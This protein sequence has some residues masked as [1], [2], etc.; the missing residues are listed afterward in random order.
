MSRIISYQ[1]FIEVVE[2]GSLIQTADKLHYSPA[3]ISKQLA[4]LEESLS[5]QLFH[6]S[7]KK[8]EITQAGKQFY[9]RCKA[10]LA[11]IAQAE[12]ALLAEQEAVSGMLCVTLSKALAR[13]SIFDALSGFT[14]LYP[15][16]NFEIRFSDQFEDLHNEN[17]DFAFRM[18]TLTDSSMIAIE[19]FKF[20]PI[21][22]ASPDFVKK[23]GFPKEL[24]ALANMPL[25]LLN[26]SNTIQK[27]WK[28]LPGMKTLNLEEHHRVNDIN[29]LYNMTK[30]GMG[31]S[32]IFKHTVA[33][34]LEEG[35]LVNLLPDYKFPE[36]PVYLMYY[37]FDYTPKKMAVFVNFFKQK[38]LSIR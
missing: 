25:L 1:I 10:I 24:Q 12:D 3:A 16:I 36:L 7:H 19:L 5:V 32:F 22:C 33:K 13:S 21:I 37:K 29:A 35:S 17:I 6:R 14:Q 8:L 30:K 15:K 18:D 11:D 2:T 38:Y 20:S 31:A 27:F 4:K 34:E 9:P 26:H 23:Y 28:S